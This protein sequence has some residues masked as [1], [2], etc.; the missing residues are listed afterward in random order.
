MNDRSLAT[1]HVCRPMY[2]SRS[3]AITERG[4]SVVRMAQE[5]RAGVAGR[6]VGAAAVSR[7]LANELS[8]GSCTDGA[9]DVSARAEQPNCNYHR[10]VRGHVTTLS[11]SLSL[12]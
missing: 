2:A 11:G 8:C 3:R 12:C 6:L 4:A 9:G 5:Q 1:R 7:K 10:L